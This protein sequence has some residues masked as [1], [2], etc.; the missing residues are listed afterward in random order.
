MKKKI[1]LIGMIFATILVLCSCGQKTVKLDKFI[2]ITYS[3]AYEGYA[4]PELTFNEEEFNKQVS[5]EAREK[6]AIK[7]AKMT[8]EYKEDKEYYDDMLEAMKEFKS[9]PELSDWFYVDFSE[10]YSKLSN[11]D[12]IKVRVFNSYNFGDSE[13]T[14]QEVAKGLGV[15]FSKTEIEYKVKGLEKVKKVP[16]DLEKL[17]TVDFGKYNGYSTPTVTINEEYL[18]GIMISDIAK[19]YIANTAVL[20][21]YVEYDD[22][23]SWLDVSFAE[24]YNNISN[25]GKIKVL[26]TPDHSIVDKGITLDELENGMML[27]FGNAEITYT[28]SGLEEAV[29][30]IDIFEGI[31]QYI[32]YEG[33]NGYGKPRSINIPQ[34]YS[35]VVGD[36]YFSYAGTGYDYGHHVVKAVYNNKNIGTIYFRCDG[37]N[38]SGGDIIEL[39]AQCDNGQFLSNG[40]IIPSWKTYVVV[41]DLGEHLTSIEQLTPERIEALK[42]YI[43]QYRDPKEICEIYYATY[44]PGYECN[45]KITSFIVPIVYKTGF[46]D[47]GYYVDEIYDVILKPDGTVTSLKNDYDTEWSGYDTLE[48]AKAALNT[49]KYTF[50]LIK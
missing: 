8:P 4:R 11:G 34:D 29:G 12:K 41:P 1:L 16:V 28:V 3:P 5:Y 2:E 35:R 20:R 46:W 19:S 21:S 26:I 10:D 30:V 38:L 25:G 45:H 47:S 13:L 24:S 33:A 36:V 49:E 9:A 7:I 22:V 48:E 18:T 17:V 32:T 14:I 44:N 39:T 6:Y 15:K 31:E 43:N 50:E 23:S 27:D 37:K 40:F 42:N